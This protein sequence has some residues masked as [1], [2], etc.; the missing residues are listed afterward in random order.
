MK[1]VTYLLLFLSCLSC[2]PASSENHSPDADLP[3]RMAPSEDLAVSEEHWLKLMPYLIPEPR[4]PREVE[5]NRMIDFALEKGISGELLPS[6]LFV[7]LT[8]GQD[9]ATI[10]WGDRLKVLYKG[11]F[12]NGT[13]FDAAQDREKPL[14]FY[15][16][17]MIAGWNEGLQL[18]TPGS[19]LLLIV[20]SFLAYGKEGLQNKKGHF[21]IPPDETL[22]FEIEVL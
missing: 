10:Q 3:D 2:K 15:V 1:K 6:G 18:A 20:P 19:R 9:T 7:S 12:L 22:V 11:Y 16:G 17:N 21:L 14:E 8:P 13:V 5:Q 4:T